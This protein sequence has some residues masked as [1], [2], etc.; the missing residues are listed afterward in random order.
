MAI[1]WSAVGAIG[2]FIGAVGTVFLFGVALLA[3]RSVREAEASRR[4]RGAAGF[5]DDAWTWIATER[6]RSR[7][8]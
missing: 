1:E 4:A 2:T 7:H 8:P 5:W 6:S 3:L